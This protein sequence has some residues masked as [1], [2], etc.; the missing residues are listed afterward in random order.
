[1]KK[2]DKNFYEDFGGKTDLK[3]NNINETICREANEETN[4]V[5]NK[6]DIMKYLKSGKY[7]YFKRG[8]YLLNISRTS[9]EF[10]ID[11]FGSSENNSD[12]NRTILWVNLKEFKKKLHF[13][14]KFKLFYKTLA[15]IKKELKN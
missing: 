7:I 14:L 4:G 9:E 2:S 13:R 15:D 11:D 1:M 10:N 12:I 3:D 5:L 6:N 8:K